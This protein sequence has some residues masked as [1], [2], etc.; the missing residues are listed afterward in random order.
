MILTALW[1]Q[2]TLTPVS[3]KN[4]SAKKTTAQ[5]CENLSHTS[6][7]KMLSFWVL[8]R[9]SLYRPQLLLTWWCVFTIINL[10][11]VLD[12]SWLFFSYSCFTE[13][14]STLVPQYP[15]PQG[16]PSSS[17]GVGCGVSPPI[18]LR[19]GLVPSLPQACQNPYPPPPSLGHLR[20]NYP[21]LGQQSQTPQHHQQASL[22]KPD[23][24]GQY[25]P[26]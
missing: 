22:V 9:H 24:R 17:G 21:C 2:T 25:A 7:T 14:H 11:A 19:Q 16:V 20:Q 18:P 8:S 13:V 6:F 5:I 10:S 12:I 1:S 3:W 15:S 4:I 26:G 23:H